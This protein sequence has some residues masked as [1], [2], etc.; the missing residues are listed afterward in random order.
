MSTAEGRLRIVLACSPAPRQ[1]REWVLDLPAG[2]TV[3]E[4]LERSPLP[5]ELPDFWAQSPAVF[6]W[7]RAASL[8][9]VLRAG[10]RIE[11]LRGLRVDPKLARRERFKRQGARAA[12]LFARRQAGQ[13]GTGDEG[14]PAAPG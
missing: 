1:V 11:L 6:V 7:G 13:G 8:Q 9:Q 4:A 5:Q 2:A 14:G 10:D 12:G 3:R